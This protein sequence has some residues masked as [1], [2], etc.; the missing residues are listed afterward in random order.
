MLLV[1]SC[2][3]CKVT[4]PVH[5]LYSLCASL[6]L[7]LLEA[8]KVHMPNVPWHALSLQE[9]GVCCQGGSSF[10]EMC[11]HAIALQ[12]EEPAPCALYRVGACTHAVMCQHMSNSA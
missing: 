3:Q 4:C 10:T 8:R 6:I 2:C 12:A 1:I 11:P 9:T 5:T 7:P